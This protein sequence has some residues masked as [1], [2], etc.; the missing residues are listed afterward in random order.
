MGI[1]QPGYRDERRPAT[2]FLRAIQENRKQRR[3][4]V[5]FIVAEWL[6]VV[7]LPVLAAKW[8]TFDVKNT[9]NKQN[10]ATKGCL[11]VEAKLLLSP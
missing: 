5:K 1:W 10:D 11:H 8:L 6:T 7:V 3:R 4:H 2:S 9:A